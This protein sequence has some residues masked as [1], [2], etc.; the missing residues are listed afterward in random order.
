MYGCGVMGYLREVD[1]NIHYTLFE[2]TQNRFLAKIGKAIYRL[3]FASIEKTVELDPYKAYLNHKLYIDA[4]K[5]RDSSSV[6]K[7]IREALA[8]WVDYVNK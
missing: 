2:I 5:A 6:A 3:F 7:K 8:E 4:I 1:L